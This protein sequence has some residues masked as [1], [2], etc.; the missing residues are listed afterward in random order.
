MSVV[1]TTRTFR[2]VRYSVRLGSYTD[3]VSILSE[4]TINGNVQFTRM[5]TRAGFQ[6]VV[7]N[8]DDV[9]FGRAQGIR[10][11][12]TRLIASARST[13]TAGFCR[14]WSIASMCSRAKRW[15]FSTSGINLSVSART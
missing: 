14:S 12:S 15:N 2:N 11:T 10:A 5:P 6:L 1:G 9:Q 4:V 13:R 7:D 8:I 3:N